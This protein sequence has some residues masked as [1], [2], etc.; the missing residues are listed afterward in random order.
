MARFTS[1][2]GPLRITVEDVSDE[3]DHGELLTAAIVS[4]I[5]SADTHLWEK[6]AT[7]LDGESP[8]PA[9]YEAVLTAVAEH[10]A[11]DHPDSDGKSVYDMLATLIDDLRDGGR[12]Q[13]PVLSDDEQT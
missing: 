11:V 6:Q 13:A 4:L 10:V 3:Y 7:E 2:D 8:T 1:T 5:G 12:L 9:F